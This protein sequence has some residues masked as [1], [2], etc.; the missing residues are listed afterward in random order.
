M[1]HARLQDRISWASNVCARAAGEWA[2]AYR[3]PGPS[4]PLAPANRFL[5]IPALFTGM[6]GK[7]VRPQGYGDALAHG[8]FDYAYTCPGDYLVQGDCIWFVAAQGRLLPALCVRTNRVISFTR[9]EA[10]TATGTNSYG[11]V[12]AATVAR[13]LTRWPASVIGSSGSGQPSADLPSD[14]SIPYWTVLL[15]A[16]PGV[17]LLPADLMSDDLGRAAIISAAELTA[18]GWRLT[19]KQAIT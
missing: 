12:T 4:D 1:R 8:I 16:V 19:V 13:L 2:D 14:S 3:A 10:P 17:V 9:A 6:Q 5:R 15:P 18:L 7:F 11:G